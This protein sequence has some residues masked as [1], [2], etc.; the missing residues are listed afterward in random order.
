MS[1]R[2]AK[3][4]V[5]TFQQSLNRDNETKH[6]YIDAENEENSSDDEQD[7]NDIPLVRIASD[8]NTNRKKKDNMEIVL[9][10]QLVNQQN[11]YL[12]AQKKIFKLQ[13]T[14]D[15]E[16]VKSRYT[17]L[18]L[19][20]VQVKLDDNRAKFAVANKK[21]FCSRMENYI[22]RVVLLVYILWTIRSFVLTWL[23]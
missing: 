22:S 5:K 21:L 9:M 6:Q 7:D 1:T 15:T 3:S 12:K 11:A 8:S 23:G 4:D 2:T 19:N 17:V 20:N 14:I 16:E 18:E 13:S 10:N